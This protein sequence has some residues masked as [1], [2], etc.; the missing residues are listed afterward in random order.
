MVNCSLVNG[1]LVIVN[2]TVVMVNGT[3]LV[4]GS[5]LNATVALVNSCLAN[6]SVIHGNVV[7]VDSTVSNSTLVNGSM[8]HATVDKNCESVGDATSYTMMGLR[9]QTEYIVSV[10]AHSFAGFGPE[11]AVHVTTMKNG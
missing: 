7:M 3:M 8:V 11:T 4:N 2:G 6:G 5:P 9:P 1:T 10:K